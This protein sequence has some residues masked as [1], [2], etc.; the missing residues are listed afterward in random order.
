[1][2]NYEFAN[3]KLIHLF[4]RRLLGPTRLTALVG[5]LTISVR[6]IS[7]CR[8]LAND[9]NSCK[10]FKEPSIPIQKALSMDGP[11]KKLR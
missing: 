5:V 4:R 1:M 9:S 11:R 7:S 6:K 8:K 3:L 2:M 10:Y